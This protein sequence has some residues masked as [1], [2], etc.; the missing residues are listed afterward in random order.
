MER[1]RKGRRGENRRW[2]GESRGGGRREGTRVK[3]AKESTRESES[4]S[5]GTWKRGKAG[6]GGGSR[7]RGAPA[8][9]GAKPRGGAAR[10]NPEVEREGAK[11][12]GDSLG[13]AAPSAKRRGFFLRKSRAFF[14]GD[15]GWSAP[16][17]RAA[18]G[19]SAQ[20]VGARAEPLVLVDSY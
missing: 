15:G 19:F 9:A 18:P 4:S 5:G 20:S 17:R 6:P 16:R 8:A 12:R 3:M 1:G 14:E 13:K 7:G 11:R 2:E 10:R